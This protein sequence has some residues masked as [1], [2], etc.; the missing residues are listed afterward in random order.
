MNSVCRRVESRGKVTA[1]RSERTDMVNSSRRSD[2][3][4]GAHTRPDI[5]SHHRL[6]QL[7]PRAVRWQSSLYIF[8]LIQGCNQLSVLHDWCVNV[9][10]SNS[11]W[12]GRKKKKK[13]AQT[14]DRKVTLPSCAT[15][16]WK[17]SQKRRVAYFYSYWV[18]HVVSLVVV[19]L[20]WC[21]V[22]VHGG[23]RAGWV[24]KVWG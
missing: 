19:G 10:N 8:F 12:V 22:S 13:V 1:A 2:G 3:S 18:I 6:L 16:L 24:I 11:H 14:G 20:T 17:H 15:S 9:W 4:G 5:C 23:D 21:H 7:C